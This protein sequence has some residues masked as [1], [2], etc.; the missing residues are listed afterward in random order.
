MQ[1]GPH[2]VG[3]VKGFGPIDTTPD[4]AAYPE[5]WEGR[6]VAAIIGAIGGGAFNVD[7]F[8]AR[9]EE[10]PPAAYWSMGYYRRWYHTL[11]R[12]L[13]VH[14]TLTAEEIAERM[15][16]VAADGDGLPQR[17]DPALMEAIEGLLEHGAPLHREAGAPP[18]FAV[19]DRVRTR[20]IEVERLGEQH[21]RLPGY[22]QERSGIVE[23]QYPAMTLPDANVRGEDRAEYLYAVSFAASDLWPDGD[24]RSRV[25]ADLFESYLE[26][27]ED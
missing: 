14:G 21:T 5:Q 7:E 12:N 18:R 25:S 22:A 19:G 11:E 8:R 2:D 26:P 27:E 3:G 4:T 6:C 23:R 24:P 13:L 17:D 10:L 1:N 20:R 16:A 9:I 15:D